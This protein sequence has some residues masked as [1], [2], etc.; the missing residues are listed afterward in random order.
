MRGI[1]DVVNGRGLQEIASR[2]SPAF[3]ALVHSIVQVYVTRIRARQMT[4]T[5]SESQLTCSS[6]VISPLSARASALPNRVRMRFAWRGGGRDERSRRGQ[7]DTTEA[8][9]H[10]SEFPI[11][12]ADSLRPAEIAS[13]LL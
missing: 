11:T 9:T 13:D 12:A 5:V 6:L 2:Y 8:E 7:C 10:R 1:C 4:R 3:L